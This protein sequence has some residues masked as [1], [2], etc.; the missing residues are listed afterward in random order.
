MPTGEQERVMRRHAG[1]CPFVHHRAP[2]LQKEDQEQG[3]VRLGCA[4]LC[5]PFTEWRPN[6]MFLPKLGWIPYRNSRE[7]LGTVT[8]RLKRGSMPSL[9]A[10]RSKDEGVRPH[11]TTSQDGQGRL[12]WSSLCLFMPVRS[13]FSA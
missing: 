5:K 11:R 13:R 12:S 6:R 7:A 4:R 2:A 9:S 3:E 8:K 10:D 1:S